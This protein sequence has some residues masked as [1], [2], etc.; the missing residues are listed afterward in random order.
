MLKEIKYQ[1]QILN[2]PAGSLSLLT[3]ILYVRGLKLM[4]T[5]DIDCVTLFSCKQNNALLCFWGKNSLKAF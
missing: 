5:R 4:L 3:L 1:R 2:V